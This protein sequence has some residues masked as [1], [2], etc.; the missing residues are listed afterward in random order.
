MFGDVL[1]RL[2]CHRHNLAH[3]LAEFI[4][5]IQLCNV[6]SLAKYLFDQSRCRL[7]SQF[8]VELFVDESGAATR[9]IHNLADKI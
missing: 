9:D 1:V 3:G 7:A 8:S 6:V 5:F 4:L 2:V